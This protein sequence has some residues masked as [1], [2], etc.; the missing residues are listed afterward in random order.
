M[1][2]KARFLNGQGRNVLE[3]MDKTPDPVNIQF[4]VVILGQRA[5]RKA[6][7]CGAAALN[8]AWGKRM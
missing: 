4:A 3:G 6:M 1:T 7:R 8:W 5:A 2:G